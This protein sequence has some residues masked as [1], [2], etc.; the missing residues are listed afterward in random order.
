M[1]PNPEDTAI[2]WHESVDSTNKVC[3]RM[4]EA[5]EPLAKLTIAAAKSQT[6]GRGQGDHLWHSASGENLTF[7]ALIRFGNRLAARDEQLINELVCPVICAFLSSEGIEARVKVPNDIYIGD[8]KICGILIENIL[9]G[10]NVDWSIIG[11][12]LNLNETDF[13]AGLPNPVSLRQLTGRRYSPASVLET[14]AAALSRR[15]E[16]LFG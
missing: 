8:R 16:E 14:L 7:S 11:I 15:L 10:P 13:P 3:R 4:L 12:G 5:G 9:D 1:S 6:A 2:I